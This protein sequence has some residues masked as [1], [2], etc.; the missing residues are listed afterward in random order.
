MKCLNPLSLFS[1]LL[2]VA[3]VLVGCSASLTAECVYSKPFEVKEL[4]LGNLLSWSTQVERE[5]Q[6]FVIQKSL[7][8]FEFTSEGVIRGA[9][10]SDEEKHYRYLDLSIG[11]EK[12]FYRLVDV[13]TRG[14]YGITHTLLMNRQLQNNLLIT[15]MDNTTTQRYLELTME[16]EMESSIR[17]RVLD[18]NNRLV[19]EGNMQ[20]LVGKNALAFD[21]G[22]LPSGKYRLS[23]Q[24]KSEREEIFFRKD[25]TI[26]GPKPNFALKNKE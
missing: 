4:E 23:L 13:D 12:V 8:G 7:D 6:T 9:L 1:N 19:E 21:F 18:M 14:N 17:Y 5:N 16:S 20:L 3:V 10:N 11:Q 26:V 15:A 2:V 24:A 22:E 25:E